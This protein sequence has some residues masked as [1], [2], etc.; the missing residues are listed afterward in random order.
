MGLKQILR[1]YLPQP[2]ANTAAAFQRN[3]QA[4]QMLQKRNCILTL[5]YHVVEHCNLNCKCC[6]TYAPLAQKEFTDI[7]VFKA[8]LQRLQELVGDRLLNL[9]LLGGEP[10]LHPDIEQFVV[11]A[12]RIFPEIYIDVVS[13]GLLTKKMP[14][15]F[16]NTLK[17]Q[18]VVFQLSSYPINLD[19]QEMMA[20]VRSKGVRTFSYGGGER[21]ATFTRKALD[22]FGQQVMY[23]SHIKCP[24]VNSTQMRKGKLYRCPTAAYVCNLNRRIKEVDPEAHEETF[25]LHSLDALDVHKAQSADEVFEFLSNPTPFCRYCAV[26]TM[27]D[28]PWENSKRDIREWVDL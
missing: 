10:L 6:S 18:N 13:N 25:R 28:V 26:S 7:E 9:H 27:Q 3:E 23:A 14:D 12:R 17:E 20:Y 5:D 11:E 4:H 1:K 21:I 15:S 24:M 8:D 2:S 22:P 16:W 19:Y